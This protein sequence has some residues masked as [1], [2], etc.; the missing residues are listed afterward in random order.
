MFPR[1]GYFEEQFQNKI[2]TT[3]EIIN[4]MEYSGE[5]ISCEDGIVAG[6]LKKIAKNAGISASGG[7]FSYIFG[8]LTAIIT[9]R[10]LGAELYGIYTLANY[11]SGIFA[12]GSRLGFGGTLI[13]FISAYKGEGRLDKAK[14]A[15]LLTLKIAFIIGGFLT[16]G[17]LLFAGPFCAILLKRPDVAP[18]FRF[19]S[20]AILFTAVYGSLIAA[21]TGFQEQRYVV[22][23]NSVCGSIFKLGSLILLVTLG[24]RLYAALAS[25]LFQDIVILSLVA[26][27]LIKV[28]PDLRNRALVAT[29]ETKKLWK[30]SG[31]LF[32]TSIFNKHTRQ[33]DLL[34]LGLFCPLRE[35]GIYA[36]ALRIQT[37]IYLPHYAISQIF[38]PIV[39]ELYARKEI[40][41]IES[42]YQTVTKWTAS[43]SIPI[44]LTIALFYEP[45][46]G[47]FGKEFHGAALT[48]IVLGIG[49]SMADAFG[50]SGQIITMIGRPGVN[51]LNSIVTACTS[52]GLYFLLIPPYGIVGAAVAYAATMM[53]V[54]CVRL[55][56]VYRFLKIHPFKRTL[57]KVFAAATVA[58]GTTYFLHCH[59]AAALSSFGWLLELLL[60]WF[61]YAMVMWVLKFDSEDL[62]ILQALKD[63]V[64]KRGVRAENWR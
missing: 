37:L 32:A 43:F 11:W 39:A 10:L 27:F 3:N 50:L 26:F 31:T 64:L 63:R 54:N 45:I 53:F 29:Q 61:T 49:N 55:L 8:P 44:F 62:V 57:W 14:G 16:A 34:F 59:N 19:Y 41:E 56:E 23:A 21:L 35:V 46:L 2:H 52:I 30:F 47:I 12:E 24:L 28:F 36:V 40:R 1:G 9:T 15:I 6:H 22:L 17:M 51:L 38:S 4:I 42:L 25:S 33:L 60:L 13:R 20:F 48:L 58:L 18:A 7:I 5:R